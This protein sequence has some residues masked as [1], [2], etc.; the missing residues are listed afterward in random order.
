M[1]KTI[2][3]EKMKNYKFYVAGWISPKQM[4]PSCVLCEAVTGITY[5]NVWTDFE[6]ERVVIYH[7]C[8]GC[9]GELLHGMSSTDTDSIIENVI[10]RK[11]EA[12]LFSQPPLK[13][14]DLQ[15]SGCDIDFE[16][17]F[18]KRKSL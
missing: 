9:G 17:L 3:L 11:L 16:L 12:F 7:L 5:C 1:L 14:S 8:E 15:K 4:I 6:E 13:F 10:E 18:P 2:D